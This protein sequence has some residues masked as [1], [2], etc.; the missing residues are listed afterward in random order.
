LKQQWAEEMNSRITHNNRLDGAD[1]LGPD[2]TQALLEADA[3]TRPQLI[4]RLPHAILEPQIEV[5]SAAARAAS[6]SDPAESRRLAEITQEVADAIGTPRSHAFAL[7]ARAAA[8]RAQGRFEDALTA[9]DGGAA[10]AERAGD[11]LLAARI[12]IAATETLAQLGRYAEALERAESLENRLRALGSEDD[13]AKVV[14]NAGNVHFQREA[15]AEAL[16]CWERAL[17]YFT[18]R[19]ETLRAARLQMNVANALTGLHRL[20]ESLRMYEAARTTL[21]AAGMNLLVA[22]VEGDIGFLRFVAGQHQDALRAYTQ[23]RQRFENLNLPHDV[24]QCDRE[25]ADVYLDLNL[26]PEARET[27]ER[28]LPV[29]RE[30]HSTAEAARSDFGLAAALF[31]Q[32]D[33][34]AAF[35]ALDRAEAAFQR[36]GNTIAAARVQLRRADFLY[37]QNTVALFAERTDTL[38]DARTMAQAA[39]KTFRRKE[40]RAETLQAKLL[41]AEIEIAAGKHPV[42]A[43]QTIARTAEKYGLPA[44]R[45]RIQAAQARAATNTG[46]VTT[47]RRQYRRAVQEIERARFLLQGDAFRIAFLHDKVRLYE[48][49]LGLLV[50][51]GET[52]AYREAFTLMEQAKSRTLLEAMHPAATPDEAFDAEQARLYEKRNDLRAQLNWQYL[53]MEQPGALSDRLPTGNTPTAE[54]IHQLEREFVQTQRK[55][56]ILRTGSETTPRFIGTTLRAIQNALPRDEQIIAYTTVHDEVLAYVLRRDGFEVVRGLASLRDVE[57]IV[58]TLR[59]QWRKMEARGSTG[60][61]DETATNSLLETLYEWLIAPLEDLLPAPRLTIVPHGILHNIPFHALFTGTDYLIDRY[62]IGYAPSCAVWKA[63][64][65]RAE[66]QGEAS[67]LF[68]LSDAGIQH[69]REELANLR[70]IL[71][72]ATVFAENEATLSSVPATGVFRYLHFATHAVFRRDNPLF[73]ALRLADGWLFAH[74][75]YT[76]RLEC[77]LATLSACHTGT[78]AVAPGDEILG[79]VRGFLHAGARAVLVSQWA[80]HDAATAALMRLFYEKMGAGSGRA[81][82]LREAQQ[83]VRKRWTH[84][85]YWAVFAIV[86]AR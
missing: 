66:P 75:L 47:A 18:E 1:K 84:P 53:R 33:Y 71:P 74:D 39:L 57:A 8:Y 60:E 19:G 11:A 3:V 37:R 36:E 30:Q 44:L 17:H 20:P 40:L 12:P 82:A 68:G 83:T 43:L 27:Y 45:W 63:C 35:G 50:D 23:A 65:E 86:G 55:L 22:G 28:V 81:A 4:A 56:D 38:T 64:R 34:G 49:L 2:L 42:R 16:A 32:G 78:G 59:F 24:A 15:F 46:N 52:K 9:F 85:F 62:E 29:F 10:Q 70:R 26:I 41:I 80:A 77:S 58:E 13:A 54:S 61:A 31:R 76:R 51:S 7:W 48:E 73:S 69:T 72:E 21:E 79:L 25:A 67:L 5:L 14:A 6:A